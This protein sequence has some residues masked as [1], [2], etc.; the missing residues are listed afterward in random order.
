VQAVVEALSRGLLK[1]RDYMATGVQGYLP[2][3]SVSHFFS[4]FL[5]KFIIKYAGI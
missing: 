1:S 3:P 5:N 2:N 4:S